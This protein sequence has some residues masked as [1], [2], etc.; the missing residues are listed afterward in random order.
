MSIAGDEAASFTKEEMQ[1]GKHTEYEKNL[2]EELLAATAAAEIA[3]S[4]ALQDAVVTNGT[5]GGSSQGTS[6]KLADAKTSRTPSPKVGSSGGGGWPN[7]S[8]AS[9][10]PTN[11]A[12]SGSGGGKGSSNIN[13]NFRSDPPERWELRLLFRL[14]QSFWHKIFKGF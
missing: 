10:T 7:L 11:S 12:S 14:T 1:Q 5:L 2:H 13:N 9:S 8:S 4:A 6:N 3:E